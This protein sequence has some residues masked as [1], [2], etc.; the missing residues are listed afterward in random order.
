MKHFYIFVFL[1]TKTQDIPQIYRLLSL[2]KSKKI[3]EH[4]ETLEGSFG[5]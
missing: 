1:K 4:N 2:K 5:R 3:E